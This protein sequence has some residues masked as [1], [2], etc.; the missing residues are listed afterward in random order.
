MTKFVVCGAAGR[1]G[2]LILACLRETPGAEVAGAIEAAGHAALGRDA[3]EVAGGAAIGVPITADF[4]AAARPD[5]VT[6]DFTIAEAAIEHLRVASAAGAAIVVGTTGFSPDVRA[7]ADALAKKTRTI[8]APNMSVGVNVLVRL[9]EE[10]AKLLGSGF[11]PEVFEVH[12]RMKV[13]APSG[14]ALALASAVATATGRE[15]AKTAVYGREGMTGKRTDAE[16]GV[17]AAR[18][19]DVVGDH[20]VYFFGMGERLELSHRAQSRECLARGAVR[21]GLWLA[22]QSKP[23]LYSMADVLGLS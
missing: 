7:E 23:G 20:T 8:I 6:L 1:M 15:L 2:R 22:K 13:D 10:A 12:H 19:G 18:G 5:T 3:G 9:V 21:A 16:L 14:T 11:D 17:L 4:A